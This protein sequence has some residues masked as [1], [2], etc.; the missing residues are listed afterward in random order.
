MEKAVIEKVYILKIKST[1][2]TLIKAIRK[3]IDDCFFVANYEAEIEAKT[4]IVD[5]FV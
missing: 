3:E 4:T 5:K 2:L 1:D